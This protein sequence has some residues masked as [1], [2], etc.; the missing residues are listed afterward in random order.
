MFLDRTFNAGHFLQSQDRIHRLGL[1]ADVKTRFTL[2]ISS[3]TIDNT[4]DGRLHDKVRALSRLMDDPGLV[5]ISLPSPDEG[6][7]GAP[8]F[9]DDWQAV[10]AHVGTIDV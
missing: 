7:G 8:A 4:V 10:A 9:E 2:L 6:E 5:Q 3:N 1:S